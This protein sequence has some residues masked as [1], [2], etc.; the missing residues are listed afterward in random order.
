MKKKT[1]TFFI[2]IIIVSYKSI[3]FTTIIDP[4]AFGIRAEGMG[5]AVV[6]L[7]TDIISAFYYNP[8][9]LTEIKGTNAVGGIY[10]LRPSIEYETIGYSKK[11]SLNPIIPYFA[12]STDKVNSVVLGVCMYTTVGSGFRFEDYPFGNRL[13]DIESKAG[14]FSLNPTIA[15]NVNQRL[16]LGAEINVGYDVSETKMPLVTPA[17]QG[18]LQTETDGFG[19]GV[20]FG[21]LYKITHS[22]NLGLSWR[23]PM[24]TH[25]EG[26][27]KLDNFE[28]DLDEDHYWPQMLA[29]GVGYKVTPNLSLGL[30]LKW[31][32]WSYFNKSKLKYRSIFPHVPITQGAEDTIRFQIGLEYFP[33]KNLAL[34]C[35]YLHDPSAIKEEMISPMLPE[36]RVNEIFCGVGFHYGKFLLDTGLNYGMLSTRR[37]TNSLTGY[38]GK[39]SG[40]RLGMG[41]EITYSW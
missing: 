37:V 20:T 18:Y 21:L 6:A 8:A 19:F 36:M 22:F 10:R 1:L 13:V 14:L 15:Y 3:G 40:Y 30:G 33:T 9:G 2:I 38:P 27:F 5:G 12:F 29:A 25:L 39:Y 31:S 32:D 16:S 24:K 34:R 41:L 23:S 17:A 35:G 11:N 7:P 28:G 4:G 26:N